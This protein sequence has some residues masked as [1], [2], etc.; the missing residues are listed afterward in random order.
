ML[1]HGHRGRAAVVKVRGRWTHAVDV[2]RTRRFRDEGLQLDG[3]G[4]DDD[5][6][7]KIMI[8]YIY[9]GITIYCNNGVL[10]INVHFLEQHLTFLEIF[11]FR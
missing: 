1:R 3:D 10:W 5:D 6:D 7:H 4:D 9:S 2:I 8:W 11:F